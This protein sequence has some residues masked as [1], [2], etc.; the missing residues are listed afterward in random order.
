MKNLLTAGIVKH[1]SSILRLLML[2]ITVPALI[3]VAS[4]Q[5]SMTVLHSFTGGSDG[6][7]PQAALVQ[8]TDG[9]LY[10]TTYLGGSNNAGTVFKVNPDGSGNTPI[11]Y[12]ANHS[13]NPF[14]LSYPSGLIQGAD[15]GLYG[16]DGFGGAAGSGSVFRLNTDGSGFTTLHS[17]SPTGGAGYEPTAALVQGR[18]GNLYGTTQ[19]G[20]NSGAGTV[21]KLGTNGTG[22]VQLYSFGGPGDAQSPQA[23]LIQGSDGFLYGTTSAGGASALGGASG[24]GTVIKINTDGTGESVLHSFLPSGNDGQR[25]YGALVQGKDGV[26]YGVTQQGGS[27]GST[28]FG[29][30]FKLNTDGSGYA[31][32]HNFDPAAGGDGSYPWSGLVLGNDGAMYGTTTYGGSHNQGVIFKLNPDGSDYAI[33]YTFGSSPGDGTHTTSPLGAGHRR[34]F[35]WHGSIWRRHEFGTMFRLAPAPAKISLIKAMPEK[36]VQIS[37]TSAPYFDYRIE[38]SVDHTHWVVLTNVYNSTGMMQITDPDAPKL[39]QRFYRAAWVP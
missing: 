22:F 7:Q 33:L 16:T 11:H 19:G 2:G 23:P 6:Q 37:L 15:G 26:L 21:F 35:I 36:S 3:H 17:F 4:A 27:G 24:Y 9:V 12:F 38:A 28:G 8:A 39:P 32:L 34:W 14:G 29:T 1:T 13:N 10:G 25:P 31:I 18:D 5:L 20:G 30:V